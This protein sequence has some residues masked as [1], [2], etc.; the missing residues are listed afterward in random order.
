MD[1]TLLTGT[2]HAHRVEIRRKNFG[3]TTKMGAVL[4][5]VFAGVAMAFVF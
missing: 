5:F 1:C 4:G 2:V 3:L